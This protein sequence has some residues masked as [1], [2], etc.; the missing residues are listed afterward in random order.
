VSSRQAFVLAIALSLILVMTV[1]VQNQ[2]V[3][4]QGGLIDK[5]KKHALHNKKYNN[6]DNM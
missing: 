3:V 5:I 1:M 4:A 6:Y 2:K